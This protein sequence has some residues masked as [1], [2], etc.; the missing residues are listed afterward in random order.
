MMMCSKKMQ[1]LWLSTAVAHVSLPLRCS[2]E[3]VI[4]NRGEDLASQLVDSLINCFSFS[5][6]LVCLSVLGVT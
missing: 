3:R 4:T 2:L 6:L 5:R 1:R